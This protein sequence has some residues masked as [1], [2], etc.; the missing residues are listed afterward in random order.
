MARKIG[1]KRKGEEGEMR[2]KE[3]ERRRKRKSEE[4]EKMEKL[5]ER[6]GGERSAI[7]DSVFKIWRNIKPIFI[8]K[9]NTWK[10]VVD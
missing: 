7:V 8:K 5:G 10:D 6:E 2:E 4:K 9:K 1:G 3:R